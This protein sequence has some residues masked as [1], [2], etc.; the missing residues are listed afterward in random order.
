V[1]DKARKEKRGGEKAK[2]EETR[3][4]LKQYEEKRSA[5]TEIRSQNGRP[6]VREGF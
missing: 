5:K 2:G 6:T 3:P 1:E 4:K